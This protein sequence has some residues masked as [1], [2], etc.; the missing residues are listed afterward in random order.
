RIF[1]LMLIIGIISVYG[2]QI[3]HAKQTWRQAGNS[4]HDVVES[5]SEAYPMLPDS[6]TVYIVDLPLRVERAWV[7]P[8]GLEDALWLTYHDDSLTVETGVDLQ[9]ALDMKKKIPNSYVFV[10]NDEI[11]KLEEVGVQKPF[12][13]Q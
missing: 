9:T 13:E 6:S 12:D 4:A 10:Y 7:F 11:S 8:V 1:S 5:V 3:L 2:S